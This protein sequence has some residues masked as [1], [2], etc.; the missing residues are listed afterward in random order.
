MGGGEIRNLGPYS[1]AGEANRNLD[2]DEQHRALGQPAP[3]GPALAVAGGAPDRDRDEGGV[4][5]GRHAEREH[6]LPWCAARLDLP[7][8]GG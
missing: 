5:Q 1:A 2:D 7:R 6:Q 3:G 8:G 4:R